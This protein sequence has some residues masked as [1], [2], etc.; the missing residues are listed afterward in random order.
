M[1]DTQR[2]A[3][4]L[5]GA[6]QAQKHVTHNEALLR[7][8]VLTQA[9]VTSR[10]FTAP[11]V[12]SEGETYLVATSASGD[13]AGGDGQLAHFRDGGW[14]FF[15]PFEGLQVF[16]EEEE[17]HVTYAAGAWRRSADMVGAEQLL[18]RSPFGAETLSRILE[19][20]L[21]DVSGGFVESA[22]IIP[23]RSLVFCVSTRVTQAITGASSFDVGLA[24][25]ISKFGGSLGISK[26]AENIGVIGPTAFYAPTGLRVTA[27]G[28]DFTGGS[29]RLSVHLLQ[30]VAPEA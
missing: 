16:V 4:P 27:N 11:P 6:A 7:L 2:L 17:I 10:A 19:V 23:D 3:L 21:T 9:S 20:E 8:D 15:S 30:P 29:L 26:G 5:L 13:W 1:S 14:V 18:A 12:A 22:A 24:G 28:G 25:E